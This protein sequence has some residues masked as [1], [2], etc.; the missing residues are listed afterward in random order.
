LSFY[1]ATISYAMASH[2]AR[3]IG[4]ELADIAADTQSNIRAESVGDSITTLKGS[5]DGPSGTPFEG[6]VYDINIQIPN[7]YPF[8][9]PVMKFAT[10]IWH[11]N[12]SSQTVSSR[13]FL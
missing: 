8:K 12:I 10:K 3:R 2:K 4:K 5:F 1:R 7:E 9:P 13:G 11:P 6:G